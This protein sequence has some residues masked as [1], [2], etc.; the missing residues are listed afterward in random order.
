MKRQS[1]LFI[2]LLVT[3][4]L[5]ACANPD[6]GKPIDYRWENVCR[7]NSF[8]ASCH[9]PLEH[10][11]FT[12]DVVQQNEK[13]Y[14]LAGEALN[15][16]SLGASHIYGGTFTFLLVKDG[17]VTEAVG[18]VPKGNLTQS[19]SF[20]KAFTTKE[21]FDGILVSYQITVK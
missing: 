17:K 15:T 13:Q 19:I 11:D 16:Q 20:K 8:P 2:M 7:C 21:E 9:L 3:I 5:S 6:I 4:M 12:F 14:S 1:I 18:I 10:F